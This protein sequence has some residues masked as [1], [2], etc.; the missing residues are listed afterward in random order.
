MGNF[1]FYP[2]FKLNKYIIIMKSLL[3]Q[4]ISK[5]I[6][7]SLLVCKMKIFNYSLDFEILLWLYGSLLF[8]IF[9][10]SDFF[11]KKLSFVNF[12]MTY[13]K[14][15]KIYLMNIFIRKICWLWGWPN[16]IFFI[17]FLIIWANVLLRLNSLMNS[18]KFRTF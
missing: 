15:L 6:D 2:T 1:R 16:F 11:C 7:D 12:S 9:I 13:H 17:K 18:W 14:F 10:N 4:I 3:V 5:F 8:Y